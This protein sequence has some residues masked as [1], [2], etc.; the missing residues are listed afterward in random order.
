MLIPAGLTRPSTLTNW[1]VSVTPQWRKIGNQVWTVGSVT[2]VSG[3]AGEDVLTGLPAPA[4]QHA[5]TA[6]QGAGSGAYDST[7]LSYVQTT[8]HLQ[9]FWQVAPGGS[10]ELA[11]SYLVD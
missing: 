7:H 11:T 8:G 1:T 5:F 3:A 4:K 6:A 10:L 2:Y 9:V